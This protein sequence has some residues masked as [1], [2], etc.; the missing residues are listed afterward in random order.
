MERKN[1]MVEVAGLSRSLKQKVMDG[2]K[3]SECLVLLKVHY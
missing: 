1:L 3:A 2:M